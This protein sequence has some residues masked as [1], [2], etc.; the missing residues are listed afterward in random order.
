MTSSPAN[1][2]LSV[3]M[4]RSS[5]KQQIKSATSRTTDVCVRLPGITSKFVDEYF[6]RDPGRVHQAMAHIAQGDRSVISDLV[7]EM[8]SSSMEEF[9]NSI[10]C[11]NAICLPCRKLRITEQSDS[12][13]TLT[14]ATDFLGDDNVESIRW[15]ITILKGTIESSKSTDSHKEKAKT[16]LKDTLAHMFLAAALVVDM[17]KDIAMIIKER[18][19]YHKLADSGEEK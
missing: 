15:L 3:E 16:F 13:P 2:F 4:L 18:D 5:I 7:K 8:M 10:P 6:D 14:D 19:E 17:Q 11:D 1:L 9:K 12:R